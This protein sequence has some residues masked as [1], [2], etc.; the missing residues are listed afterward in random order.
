MSWS[1]SAV[2]DSERT[3]NLPI[4]YMCDRHT[5][6]LPESQSG[7]TMSCM[8]CVL[9]CALE[10]LQFM[11]HLIAERIGTRQPNILTIIL[12]IHRMSICYA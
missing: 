10:C 7:E 1:V 11:E 3:L 12:C 5:I 6:S 8:A 4:S 9:G 2:G